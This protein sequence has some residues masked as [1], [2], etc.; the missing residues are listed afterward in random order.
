MISSIENHIRI[1]VKK[2]YPNRKLR[3]NEV[4]K[5]TDTSHL[6]DYKSIRVIHHFGLELLNIS[7]LLQLLN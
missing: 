4:I 7:M 3:T 1:K 6:T 5:K 2:E